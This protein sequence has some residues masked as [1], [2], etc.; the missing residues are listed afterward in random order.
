[1][2]ITSNANNFSEFISSGVDPR[3]GTYSFSIKLS[4]FLSHK[5]VGVTFSLMLHYSASSSNDMGFGRGWALALSRFDRHSN[6]LSLST[7]QN[8][9][10][11]F[12]RTTN[13]YDIPYR[14][15]KDV[16]VFYDDSMSAIKVVYKDGRQEFI[17]YTTGTMTKMV[18]NQGLETHFSYTDYNQQKVLWKIADN[19]GRE[20][21]ID[22]WSSP[23]KVTITDNVNNSL[24]QKLEV[25]KANNGI[26]QRLA[27]VVLPDMESTFYLEYEYA[28]SNGYDLITRVTHP[29]GMVERMTYLHNGHSLPEDA[30][31]AS[32]PYIT[33]HRILPGANQFPQVTTYTYSDK[34]YL[35]FA[36]ERTFIAGE[37]TL[38]KARADYEYSSTETINNSLAITRYYNKY[39]L[40]IR[41]DYRRNGTLYR[42]ENNLYFA[43]TNVAIEY[44]PATYTLLKESRVTHYEDGNSRVYTFRYN[45]DDYGNQVYIQESNGDEV[46]RTFY[47]S[48]G[49]GENCP[50]EPNGFV[51]FLKSET[52][53]PAVTTNGEVE[54]TT[55]MTYQSLP[56]IGGGNFIVLK[57]TQNYL[58]TID[59]TYFN[60]VS[61]LQHGQPKSKST[62][63]NNQTS[64]DSIVYQYTNT[65]LTTT[66]T[67]TTHDGLSATNSAKIRLSDGQGFESTNTEGVKSSVDYDSLGRITQ[68]TSAVGTI[69]ETRLAY[70]YRVG[71]GLNQL[72]TTDSKGNQQ[73]ERYNNAGNTISVSQSDSEG[74]L[75]ELSTLNYNN[76]GQLISQTDLDYLPGNNTLSLITQYEYDLRGEVNKIT[77]PDGRV[78]TITQSPVSLTTRYDIRGLMSEISLL[79][80]TG[81]LISKETL[82]SAGRRLA[83]TRNTYDGFGN[84]LTVTD[85]S[86]HVTEYA[87]DSADRPTR[88]RRMVD[89]TN[90]DITTEYASFSNDNLPASIYVNNTL[91]GSRVYDGLLRITT[92]TSTSGTEQRHYDSTFT[93]PSSVTT[94]KNETLEFT[95]NKNLEVITHSSVRGQADLNATYTHD[96]L[97]GAVTQHQNLNSNSQYVYANNGTLLEESAT[98]S[99]NVLRRCLY[100]YSPAGRLLAKTD[101]F[102]NNT[103]YN[104]DSYGRLSQISSTQ[105][106]VTTTSIFTY[107]NYSRVTRYDTAKGSDMVSV[108]ITLNDI[109]LETQRQVYLNDQLDFSLAQNFNDDLQISEKIY[110]QGGETTTENM[111]YDALHRLTNYQCTGPNAPA[112]EFGN[113]YQRQQFSYDIYGN[114]TRVISTFEDSSTNTAQFVY[115]AMDPVRL[116]ALSNTHGDYPSSLSF[117][118]DLAGNLLNDEKGRRYTYDALN[119]MHSISDGENNVLSNYSYDGTGTLVSQTQN[120]ALIYLYYQGEELVNELSES[121]HSSYHKIGGAVTGR[122]VSSDNF[123]QHQFLLQNAQGSTLTTWT[124]PQGSEQRTKAR[125]SYTPY[126]EG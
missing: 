76:F 79:D 93:A 47:S 40:Q 116:T 110:Q 103:L 107:D 19:A 35:G 1:M 44:Q 85:T 27:S 8:F 73:V 63:V 86:G 118:Y 29:T 43:E 48:S 121:V 54:R 53:Q 39:H 98:F 89:G 52:I 62:T 64:T 21:T 102:G 13:E 3:T 108:R 30:P 11:E 126:G 97:T 111:T 94:A 67:V 17:D 124:K 49:E 87:Y 61:A 100:T 99:D 23:S 106:G 31:I 74:M 18:S 114:I 101:Y 55:T 50:A 84:L 113:S 115:D 96:P 5:T 41:A 33:E 10:I 51:S 72:T 57:R 45:Y 120:N 81:Q 92:E 15:L 91:I 59:Y 83:Y 80:L 90:V 75:R 88:I 109:G 28:A 7:G 112:D 9:K 36:S 104:Y 95:Y 38:F 70:V 6:N 125:R 69:N 68:R 66:T 14:K 60:D 78:E 105:S 32:A 4:E 56:K 12:N 46:S 58:E 34:N 119:Q 22:T 71:A 123:N 77:H 82:D 25:T 65:T 24:Y 117:E 122:T 16:K 37:D 2:S 20:L 26:Y 42:Q